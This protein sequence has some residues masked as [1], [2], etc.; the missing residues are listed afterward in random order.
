[1]AAVLDMITHHLESTDRS[2]AIQR[3]YA[4]TRRRIL[5]RRDVIVRDG[6]SLDADVDGRQTYGMNAR[7]IYHIGSQR[8]LKTRMHHYRFFPRRDELIR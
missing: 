1:M 8:D 2:S 3:L 7:L 5:R 4:D 6:Y